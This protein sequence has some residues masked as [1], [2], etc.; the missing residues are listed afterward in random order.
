MEDGIGMI[1]ADEMGVEIEEEIE[2]AVGFVVVD[3]PG[4]EEVS[5]VVVAFAFDEAGEE[6][7]EF[8]IAL[9][10]GLAE[11]LEFFA[12]SAFD[13]GG[14]EQVIDGLVTFAAADGAHQATDPGAGAGFVE[15]DAAAFEQG[16]DELEVL[17]FFDGDGVEFVDA[18]EEVPILLE[19][20]GAGGGLALEVGMVDEDGRELIENLGQPGFR[21]LSAEEEH[22]I[23]R[24]PNRGGRS[25]G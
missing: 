19:R 8:G 24:F 11:P 21:G 16:E 14:A 18:G 5:G 2:A 7:G 12:T 6:G 13:E 3:I 25:L 17:Q 9:G 4:H 1:L 23:R 22:G 20:K 10:E 15:G